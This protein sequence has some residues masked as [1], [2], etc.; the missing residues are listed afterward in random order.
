MTPRIRVT[1]TPYERGR[2]YGTQARD[3]VPEQAAQPGRADPPAPLVGDDDV[4][5][6]Q[7]AAA[8]HHRGHR[9]DQPR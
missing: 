5:R 6:G 4:V 8:V 1:G 9:R 2:Q 7:R 3:Q